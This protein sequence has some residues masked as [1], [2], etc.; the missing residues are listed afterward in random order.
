MQ[1]K[2][3]HIHL[4]NVNRC[5]CSIGQ[6]ASDQTSGFSD[7]CLVPK[8]LRVSLRLNI[9]RCGPSGHEELELTEARS[10]R[11]HK[12]NQKRCIHFQDGVKNERELNCDK[13][14]LE[15]DS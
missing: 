12:Y 5:P 1:E 13:F 14:W 4:F 9:V 2:P 8:G 3:K 10:E 7:C 11:K 6:L 15:L